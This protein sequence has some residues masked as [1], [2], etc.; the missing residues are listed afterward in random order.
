MARRG[1]IKNEGINMNTQFWVET[2]IEDLQFPH[3][4]TSEIKNSQ[5]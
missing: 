1:S 3:I 5:G 4:K 2:T